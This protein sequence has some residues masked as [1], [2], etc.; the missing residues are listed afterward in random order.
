MTELQDECPKLAFS[1]LGCPDWTWE[2]IVAGGREFGYRGIEIRMLRGEVDLPRVPEFRHHLRQARRRECLD[3]GLEICGLASSIRFHDREDRVR[4]GQFEAGKEFLNLAADLGGTFIRV[5]GDVLSDAARNG[6]LKAKRDDLKWI[7]EGLSRMGELSRPFGI[8]ILL[9]THGDFTSTE[10]L[11]ELMCQVDDP[12]VGLLWDT[13][14]P[15]RF[16]GEEPSETWKRIGRWVRHTHWKDSD[17][18]GSNIR[19]ELSE[20]SDRLARELMSGHRSAQYCRFGEGEFPASKCLE[21]IRSDGYCG[22]YCLEWEKAWHPE[23]ADAS[24]IFPLFADR[25]R[26]MYQGL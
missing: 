19:T 7:A 10:E 18:T 14:H 1:T 12:Q 24:E 20:R 17:S 15:W 9:E 8:S 6:D 22:W 3:A 11:P 13:H 2:Q 4:R 23:I 16:E 25:F 26:S 21:S 5:F